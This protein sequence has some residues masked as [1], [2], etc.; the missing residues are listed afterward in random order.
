MW[1]FKKRKKLEW[2]T[3]NKQVQR[4]VYFKNYERDPLISITV[5]QYIHLPE[6]PMAKNYHFIERARANDF[7]WKEN[8]GFL[9]I[10]FNDKIIIVNKEDIHKI[11]YEVVE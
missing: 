1:P 5:Q 7:E 3:E 4:T 9:N 11:T 8:C 6:W 2:I 10:N